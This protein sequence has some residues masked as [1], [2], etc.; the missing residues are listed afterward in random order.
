MINLNNKKFRSVSNTDNGEVDEATIFEYH[1]NGKIIWAT[2]SGGS[3]EFGTLMGTMDE[4]GVISFN[5]Q[6]YNNDDEYKIGKCV[7]T[8]QILSNN[9][10]R[11]YEKW[12][13]LNGDKSSGE[14]IIEEV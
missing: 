5:Y 12:Q 9:K 6:H 2:Y 7:S 3:I 1:Q 4:N 13:W 14:S 10:I 8:P 11:Y